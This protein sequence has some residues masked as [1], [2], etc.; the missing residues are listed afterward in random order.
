MADDEHSDEADPG[1]EP[2]YEAI[3]AGRLGDPTDDDGDSPSL[4]G[5][6]TG[7]LVLSLAVVSAVL[8]VRSG[9]FWWQVAATLLASLGAGLVLTI[10]SV[11][12]GDFPP[13]ARGWAYNLTAAALVVAG[14]LL[15][16]SWAGQPDG[17]ADSGTDGG[18]G[19][20]TAGPFPAWARAGGRGVVL[21]PVSGLFLLCLAYAWESSPVIAGVAAAVIFLEVLVFGAVAAG[22]AQ[23][24]SRTTGRILAW[25]TAGVL[26]VGN[27][28][29][30]VALLPTVRSYERVVVAVNIERDDFGRVVA[31]DCL[32][33]FRGLAEVYHTE[34][35]VWMAAGNPLVIFALLAGE[36]NPRDDSLAW[37]PGELQ[38][39]A[40]GSQVPCVEGQ[41][42]NNTGVEL[43][44]A[45]G[46]FVMQGV[47][48]G[49][50]LGSGHLAARRR[51]G[52]AG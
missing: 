40:E 22:A 31:Y 11:T 41:D 44:L 43:P 2:V 27:V 17:I 16:V 23:W 4:Q 50:F 24:F 1:G 30:V 36:A 19:E 20:Q 28:V 48:A 33:E 26:L 35:I 8:S 10:V 7:Q 9:K 42:R 25:S 52:S 29:A 18:P 51:A 13:E 14:C 3:R 49:A 47:L 5:P 39:A 38:N 6:G 12:G 15:A 32:P 34:R 21:A 46:G 45:A 37:L